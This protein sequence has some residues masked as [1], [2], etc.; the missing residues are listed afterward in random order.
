MAVMVAG[1]PIASLLIAALLIAVGFILPAG[2][3]RW[4]AW[5]CG[6]MSAMVF[7]ATIVPIRSSSFHSDGARL[8]MYWFRRDEMT[9]WARSAALAA[10]ALSST[11]PRDWPESIIVEAR[12]SMDASMDGIGIA[13]M[14]YYRE[15]DLGNLD[16]AASCL[17]FFLE[18]RNQYPEPFRP[19]LCLEGAWFEGVIRKRPG[20]ARAW[21]DQSSG[22]VMVEPQ[23]RLRSEAAVLYSEGHGAAALSK[24][25]EALAILDHMKTRIGFHEAERRMLERIRR[26]LAEQP[27]AISA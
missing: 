22:G 6:M 13:S 4:F 17:D 26:V 15:L 18:H 23:S 2:G 12:Q 16:A 19:A 20:A 10:L 21:L 11:A 27:P 3:S 1:G 14:L 25:N 5:I 8:L 24:A 9:R 7:L